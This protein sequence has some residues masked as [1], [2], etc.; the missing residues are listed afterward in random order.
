MIARGK[1]ISHTG[2]ALGYGERTKEKPETAQEVSRNLVCGQDST[3]I[4]K[5]FQM[6]QD[7]N[8]RCKKNTLA[9]VISPDANNTESFK[10]KDYRQIVDNFLGELSA[11]MNKDKSIKRDDIDL[12]KNNQHVAYIHKDTK[13]THI[14][15]YVNRIELTGKAVPDNHLAYKSAN[16][17][18]K[19]AQKLNLTRAREVMRDK[20]NQKEQEKERLKQIV[21]DAHETTLNEKPTTLDQYADMMKEKGARP[22]FKQ[23]KNKQIVGVQFETEKGIIK[24]SAVASGMSA[25]N[26]TNELTKKF[27]QNRMNAKYRGNNKGFNNEEITL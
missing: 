20:I 3:E 22:I 27:K 24:G 17:A 9:F 8:T 4:F 10:A 23:A 5:E 1:A 21:L 7:T 18:D 15:L 25:K 12:L 2:N 16:A 19:V 13:T 6:F 26:L 11:N 14:H